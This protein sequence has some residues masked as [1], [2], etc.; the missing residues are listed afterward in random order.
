MHINNI[1]P[2]GQ[3]FKAKMTK[4]VQRGFD[5]LGYKIKRDFGKDS[6]AYDRYEKCYNSIKNSN[7]NLIIDYIADCSPKSK[8]NRNRDY[9]FNPYCFLVTNE[10]IGEVNAYCS[11]MYEDDL[12]TLKN[13]DY[14]SKIVELNKNRK[15]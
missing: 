2:S 4:A 13:L 5:N 3:S 9:V 15:W 11:S 14:L 8:I 7:D 12:Y 6:E 1:T 10:H